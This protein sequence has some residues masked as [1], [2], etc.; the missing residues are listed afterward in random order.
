[1]RILVVEDWGVVGS[2]W[3]RGAERGVGGLESG[4]EDL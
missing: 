4:V 3:G 2:K 1:M